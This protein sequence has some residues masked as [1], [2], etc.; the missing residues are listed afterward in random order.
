MAFVNQHPQ[1]D[2]RI[3]VHNQNRGEKNSVRS[4]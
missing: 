1:A 2:S 3:I 4:E